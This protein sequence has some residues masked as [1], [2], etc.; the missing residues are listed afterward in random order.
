M[1]EF[2][3]PGHPQALKRH[4][5]FRCGKR[6]I[7]VD[8]SATQKKTFLACALRYRPE[9]PLDEPLMVKMEFSFPRPKSHFTRKGLKPSAPLL[10]TGKPDGT[11]LAKFY[12]DALNGIFWRDDSVIARLS[13]EKRY[14]EAP[15]IFISIMAIK[16][17]GA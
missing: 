4:R 10:H 8:A 12:E 1:I 2:F 17:S 9:R 15:G 14:A 6:N 3:I 13:I 16:A 7:N 11:N 5:T